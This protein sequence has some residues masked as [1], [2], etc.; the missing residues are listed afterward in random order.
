MRSRTNIAMLALVGGLVYGC[1]EHPT[2]PGDS[3]PSF[4]VQ[5]LTGTSTLDGQGDH[6]A[7]VDPDCVWEKGDMFTVPVPISETDVWIA[8]VRMKEA[9]CLTRPDGS[10]LFKITHQ[11]VSEIPMPTTK[12]TI[13]GTDEAGNPIPYNVI[14]GGEVLFTE[15]FPCG[16]IEPDVDP[17]FDWEFNLSPGGIN[18][19]TCRFPAP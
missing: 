12:V 7:I 19:A 18:T 3:D 1:G 9:L 6:G 10:R 16:W 2:S 11:V 17:T 14:L 4:D 13:H 8:D 5:I 15:S